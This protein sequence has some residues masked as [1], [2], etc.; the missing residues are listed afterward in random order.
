MG[1]RW[2]LPLEEVWLNGIDV[3]GYTPLELTMVSIGSVF[4]GNV[5]L[6]DT[7]RIMWTT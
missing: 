7:D 4:T 3:T 6:K 1:R 5:E 2:R